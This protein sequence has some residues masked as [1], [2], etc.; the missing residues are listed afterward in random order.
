MLP[1]SPKFLSKPSS[2]KLVPISWKISWKPSP[3]SLRSL[4]FSSFAAIL[5][6]IIFGSEVAVDVEAVSLHFGCAPGAA[7]GTGG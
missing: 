1:T 4:M 7:L 5:K 2:K 6:V 3:K